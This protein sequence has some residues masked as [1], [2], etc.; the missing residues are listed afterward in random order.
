MKEKIIVE[1][2]CPNCHNKITKEINRDDLQEVSIDSDRQ[3]G[4]EIIYSK[5]TDENCPHCGHHWS[6]I[7]VYEYPEGGYYAIAE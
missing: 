5:S 7:N 2:E 1:I 3:M 6:V 4:S